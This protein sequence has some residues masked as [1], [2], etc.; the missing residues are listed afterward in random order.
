MATKII[1]WSSNHTFQAD[2]LQQPATLDEL[3]RIVSTAEKVH[4][5]GS[6]HSFND[7]AESPALVNLDRM[8]QSIEVDRDAR[9]VTVSAAMRYSTLAVALEQ[10]GYA[11]HNMASLPHITVGG[12]VATATHGSGDSSRN[13]ASAVTALEIVTSDGDVLQYSRKDPDFDGVVVGIGAL[14]VV[15]RF[16]LDIEPSYQ[17]KQEIFEWL[18]WETLFSQFDAVT[19][20]AESVSLFTDFGDNVNQV[21]LKFRVDPDH[22][23]ARLDHFLGAPAATER[24]NPV[25]TFSAEQCTEQLGIPGPWLDR[26]PHVRTGGVSEHG[27]QLQTEYM[28]S[29]ECAVPALQAVKALAPLIRPHLWISE[30]RTVAADN[31][32][33]STS[34]QSDSV[35]IHFSWKNEPYSVLP[36]L[37][38]VEEALAPFVPRPHWGKLFAATRRDLEGRYPRFNDFR[39]LASRLDPRG[40][41][42]NGYLNRCL[43]D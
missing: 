19:S 12:A 39:E 26:L 6:R 24:R 36:L 21:W 17:V 41:F 9:T 43:F 14:G 34:Y 5:I 20:G 7:I 2:G 27:D 11:L 3:R 16:T 37:P 30:I 4:A 10:A 29:R 15:T 31:L 35:C 23:T 25:V 28:V 38:L 32:W 8:D 1:N 40:A 22:A 18:P 42:R 13:L 33:L